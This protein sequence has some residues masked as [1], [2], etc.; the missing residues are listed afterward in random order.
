LIVASA[1]W[2][3]SWNNVSAC[4]ASYWLL[5]MGMALHSAAFACQTIRFYR[6]TQRYVTSTAHAIFGADF[7]T[8]RAVAITYTCIVVVHVVLAAAWT[9][10][11]QPSVLAVS[12]AAGE[13]LQPQY[14]CISSRVAAE[15]AVAH[16]IVV[17]SILLS[18]CAVL[19]VAWHRVRIYNLYAQHV[20]FY[21]NLLAVP[22]VANVL[23]C[24][25][26]FV[27]LL[28]YGMWTRDLGSGS[29]L[30]VAQAQ[31]H[32]LLRTICILVYSL[33]TSVLPFATWLHY[34]DRKEALW[35]VKEEQVSQRVDYSSEQSDTEDTYTPHKP[36]GSTNVSTST[37]IRSPVEAQVQHARSLSHVHTTKT[38]NDDESS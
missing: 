25:I 28:L 16:G 29:V 38:W 24:V 22:T 1:T 6:L 17:F 15:V 10:V 27:A 5:S 21:A 35:H 8:R 18:T 33:L 4:I 12:P 13:S 20:R 14:T 2:A 26:I 23:G 30:S 36:Q 34:S 11:A 37:A 9:T 19:C 3:L 32:Y 31:Q 7:A